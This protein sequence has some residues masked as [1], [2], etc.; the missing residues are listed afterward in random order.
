MRS[1]E[2]S[3]AIELAALRART[4]EQYANTKAML[5]RILA[6]AERQD[7]RLDTLDKRVTS[8]EAEVANVKRGLLGLAG[9]ALPNGLQWVR[10]LLGG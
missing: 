7:E 5:E 2:S 4:E 9:A 1:D 3:V 6:V 10:T 8:N